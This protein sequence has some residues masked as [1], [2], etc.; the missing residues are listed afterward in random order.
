MN[1]GIVLDNEF[2]NDI[3]V[4]KEVD[5]L[6]KNGYNV[7]VLCYGLSGKKYPELEGVHIERIWIQKKVKDFIFLAHHTF[8]FYINLWKKRIKKFIESNQLSFLHVHDLFMSKPAFLGRKLARSNCKIFLD[9]HENFPHAVQSYNWTKGWIRGFLSKPKKWIQ[10]EYEYLDYADAIIVLSKAYEDQ[11]K[12]K[13]PTLKE[14]E[15]IVFPNV[16]SFDR[17]EK[18]EID[19]SKEKKQGTTFLYFGVVAERRGIFDALF[20]LKKALEQIKNINILIIGPIDKSDKKRF[21]EFLND[22]NLK[23]HIEYVPWIDISELV[24]Y[25]NISDA[26]LAPFL[27][28]PQHDSGVANKIFQYMFGKKPIIASNCKPQ[29][30]L[31]ESSNCGLV[32][33]NQNELVEH[34]LWAASHPSELVKMG[35]NGYNTLYQKFKSKEFELI[36]I[37]LYEK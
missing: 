12:A 6:K 4:R 37:G 16:I 7:F 20:A 32:F 33:H 2:N 26:C 31:I 14:K 10:V 17:F 34:L 18:F 30:E 36:L 35:N 28:N 19:F 25:M 1:V 24:T 21:N 15:F 23:E 27:K 5:I 8:P 11:L 22:P 9:L 29:T 3:R 13:Y